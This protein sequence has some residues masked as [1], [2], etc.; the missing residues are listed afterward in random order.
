M[1]NAL[2]MSPK[3]RVAATVKGLPVDRVPVFIW[4]N[5]HTGCKLMTEY[6]P[7][8]YPI[9]NTMAKLFWNRFKNGGY[10]K[11]KEIWRTLPMTFDIHTFNWA[12]EYGLELGSDILIA[13]FATPVRYTTMYLENKSLRFRDIF[14]VTRA[15]GGGIY[16]DMIKPVINNINE[17][18]S[19]RAPDTSHEKLYGM[20]RKVRKAYPEIFIGAEVWGPQDFTNTSM[21]GTE[22]FMTALIEYPDEM[23]KFLDKWTECSRDILVRSIRAGANA[24]FIEDDYGY[25]NRTFISTRMWD[26]FTYPRLK[27]LVD[28]AHEEG[29]LAILHS[30]GFQMPLL[31]FYVK[32]GID[33]IQAFQPN[34]G[35]DFAG[36]YAKYGDKL[37]FITGIDAQMGEFMTPDELKQDIVKNYKIG[38][39][40]GRH[41]LGTTHEIQYTMPDKNMEAIFNTINEVQA[42]EHD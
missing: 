9:R 14:G 41:V 33:M 39:R 38:G 19:Y 30:C 34:A 22:N 20:F 10:Q 36:A 29:A 11:S 25:D 16:P 37:T 15:M 6:K 4:L 26:E 7:S 24:V 23:K 18:L 17:A 28:A 2:K 13:S 5:A 32:A 21:F 35:N 3:E 12:N 42:G 40:K 27:K 8:R 1:S 31:D